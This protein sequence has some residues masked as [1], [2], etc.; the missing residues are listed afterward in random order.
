MK[1]FKNCF[2]VILFCACCAIISSCAFLKDMTTLPPNTVTLK[3]NSGG[4]ANREVTLQVVNA[5]GSRASGTVNVLIKC[6]KPNYNGRYMIGDNRTFAID[7][8]GVRSTPVAHNASSGS[9][10]F[11]NVE[12][13]QGGSLDVTIRGF[14]VSPEATMLKTLE[15]GCLSWDG[16]IAKFK[17]IPITWE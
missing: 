4:T 9:P 1:N 16:C 5:K 13:P 10:D 12:I 11:R 2:S 17:D 8:K 6:S 7:D 3:C 14:A 15:I